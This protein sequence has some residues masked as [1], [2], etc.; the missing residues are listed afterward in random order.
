MFQP[1]NQLMLLQLSPLISQVFRHLLGQLL[2]QLEDPV[3]PQAV[4][5]P[6]TLPLSRH[7]NPL[8]VL[9]V[10]LP[11]A[12]Q[13]SQLQDPLGNLQHIR[14][15]SR[16][17]IHLQHRQRS[18]LSNLHP[19]QPVNRLVSPVV[20]LVT[21]LL[22]TLLVHRHAAP[23]E[24]RLP[25]QHNNLPVDPVH[26]HQCLLL[27]FLLWIHLRSLLFGRRL[28]RPVTRPRNQ[29]KCHLLSPVFPHHANQVCNHLEHHQI[30]H[31]ATPRVNQLLDQRR[32]LLLHR[33]VVPCQDQLVNHPCNQALLQ[34]SNRPVNHHLVH[35]ISQQDNPL[36]DRVTGL[37]SVLRVNHLR[38][39]LF[40]RLFSQVSS[41]VVLRPCNQLLLHLQHLLYSQALLQ[42][43]HR[44]LNHHHPLLGNQV[45]DLQCCLVVNH[46][47]FLL[48]RCQLHSQ[49]PD[50]PGNRLHSLQTFRLVS[51]W[52]IR[53]QLQ[54]RNLRHFLRHNRHNSQLDDRLN[55]RQ[56]ALQHNRP[57]V[58]QLCLQHNL[59]VSLPILHLYYPH[60]NHPMHQ[61][62]NLRSNH[63]ECHH[64]NRLQVHHSSPRHN[65]PFNRL[66]FRQGNHQR[67]PASVPPL[68]PL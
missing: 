52:R 45:V 61:Q 43:S 41:Q 36:Q 15:A 19:H 1:T 26:N 66:A 11:I 33:R 37:L 18:R 8:F 29:L 58:L 23:V 49:H 64:L 46:L 6:I 39:L 51:H 9:P 17:L 12:L 62:R 25:L 38:S 56:I 22:Q 16:V 20:N 63:R 47:H 10:N 35:R 34:P 65:L 13:V 31:H 24:N 4:F 55:N 5:L 50:H 67:N 40:G 57:K 27:H 14:L 48:L 28:S 42:R 54:A 59:H 21:S 44:R 53:H 7:F 2:F 3:R 68:N 60:G 32:C 30:F